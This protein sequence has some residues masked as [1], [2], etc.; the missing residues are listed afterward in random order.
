VMRVIPGSLQRGERRLDAPSLLLGDQA[1][2]HLAEVRMLGAG[3]DVLP[4]IGLEKGA[5]ARLRLGRIDGAAAR[6]HEVTRVGFGLRLQ[7]AVYR[8]NQRDE[9]V[10][11][12]IALL[13]RYSGVMP[14]PFEFV[15][16]RSIALLLSH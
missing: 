10:D 2:E 4:A 11:R 15:D 6:L 1:R 13:R 8:G 7:D 5:L 9:L 3:V 12:G 14:N 16:A